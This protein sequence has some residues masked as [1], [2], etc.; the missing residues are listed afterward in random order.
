MPVGT[1]TP[2]SLTTITPDAAT[3]L[4][5]SLTITPSPTMG[6]TAANMED[7]TLH[8]LTAET[9]LANRVGLGKTIAP[10]GAWYSLATG[11]WAPLETIGSTAPI[12]VD[13]S[14]LMSLDLPHGAVI[15]AIRVWVWPRAHAALPGTQAE[16]KLWRAELSPA[17]GPTTTI[18]DGVDST[19]TVGAYTSAHELV[20]S[21]SPH[22]TLDRETYRYWIEILGETGANKATL[23]VY[24]PR[25]T[26]AL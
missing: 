5:A 2:G 23:D 19:G 21:M 25:F 22:I 1:V 26:V 13:K 20:F 11:V 24:P 10:S 8:A 16:V 3:A 7:L 12:P 18:F 17:A 9:M 4:P 14:A 15:T 6:V